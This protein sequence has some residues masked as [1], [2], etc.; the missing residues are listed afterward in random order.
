MEIPFL[1]AL[2]HS[3]WIGMIAALFAGAI[4]LCGRR[5]SSRVRYLLLCAVLG[6]FV[7]AT[8]IKGSYPGPSAAKETGVGLTQQKSSIPALVTE[9]RG[10]TDLHFAGTFVAFVNHNSTWI[11]SAWLLFFCWHTIRLAGGLLYIRRLKHDAIVESFPDWQEKVKT[12]SRKLGVQD[13]VQLLRSSGISM[14]VTIGFFK[15]VI[16]LP[17]GLLMQMPPAHIESILLHELAHIQRKDY[18]VNLFQQCVETIFFFNPAVLWISKLIREER[19]VCCDDIVLSHVS[20]K[21]TYLQALLA[22][23]QTSTVHREL[24]MA[25]GGKRNELRNRFLRMAGMESQRL[26]SREAWMLLAGVVLLAVC[27]IMANVTADLKQTP[28]ASATQTVTF[29]KPPEQNTPAVSMPAQKKPKKQTE[30][31][32]AKD[33]TDWMQ[34]KLSKQLQAD[35]DNKVKNQQGKKYEPF[36]NSS[37][38]ADVERIKLVVQALLAEGI[39]SSAADIEWFGLSEK[40]LI[41]NG[42][43]QSAALHHQLQTKTQVR[44]GYGLFYGP[45]QMTGQGFFLDKQDLAAL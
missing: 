5:W 18:L 37:I 21:T 10:F 25:I 15:P 36:D 29:P 45:V 9:V 13:G 31:V 41:V 32:P 39:V 28:V 8:C 23:Q 24:A 26:T 11:F 35:V 4:I 12:L 1:W 19:E 34:Y 42:K 43:L 17:A 44:P 2:I 16:L 14:P 38:A 3:L 6:L 7:I 22:F 40:E 27:S 30:P 20:Q 33:T